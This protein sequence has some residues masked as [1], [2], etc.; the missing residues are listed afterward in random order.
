MTSWPEYTHAWRQ[1]HKNY[2]L[3]TLSANTYSIFVSIYRMTLLASSSIKTNKHTHFMCW[4]RK[5][6]NSVAKERKRFCLFRNRMALVAIIT[7]THALTMCRRKWNM[8]ALFFTPLP[9]FGEQNI[10]LI[11]GLRGPVF[12]T[13]RN[14][15]TYESCDHTIFFLLNCVY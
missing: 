12:G 3:P 9:F 7:S 5:K 8:I 4:L 2:R 1:I 13:L 10:V 6:V 14:D 15:V 11:I